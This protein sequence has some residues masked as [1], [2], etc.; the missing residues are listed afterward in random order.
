MDNFGERL[1]ELRK[2]N[3]LT[4]IK[5]AKEI[6]YSKSIISE[7]ENNKKEPTATAIVSIAMFFNVSTDYLLGQ[8]DDF[9]NFQNN[10]ILNI[11]EK[12]L[13]NCYNS[14]NE[15]RKNRLLSYAKDLSDIEKSKMLN[16]SIKKL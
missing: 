3:E 2:E 16:N 8:T 1:K 10:I 11:N 5:L 13:L 14:L 9:G 15:S 7:W 6:K 4:I 12:E